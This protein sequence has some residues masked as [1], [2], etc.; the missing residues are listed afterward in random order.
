MPSSVS[1]RNRDTQRST[2][3]RQMWRTYFPI[4]PQ[5][6]G[7]P[8]YDTEQ[9]IYSV[10]KPNQARAI[11]ELLRS[12]VKRYCGKSM[13]QCVLTDATACVGGDTISFSRHFKHVNAVELQAIHATILKHNLQVYQRINVTVHEDDYTKL[14][15]TLQQDVVFI[16]PPWGGRKYKNCQQTRLYLSK[17]PIGYI[18]NKLRGRAKLVILK[19]PTN[20]A[21][22][23]LFDIPGFAK[24]RHRPLFQSAHIHHLGNMVIIVLEMN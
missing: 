15:Y 3:R 9:A 17:H 12:Y 14:A 20:F 2:S 19:V 7:I 4:E 11:I 13:A 10:T 22:G 1:Q 16:D 23:T 24:A 6:V 5:I 8:K 18:V 21:I